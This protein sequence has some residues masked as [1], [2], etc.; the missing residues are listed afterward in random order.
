MNRIAMS[1][2][3][4][5]LLRRLIGRAGVPRDRILLTDVPIGRLAVADL[6]R[7][8]APVRAARSG[9]RL[10]Q[11]VE[12]MCEGLED[13]EFS[14]PGIIVADIGPA[15]APARALDGSTSITIE[16]LT[17]GATSEASGAT[18]QARRTAPATRRRDASRRGGRVPPRDD[19]SIRDLK[20]RRES[21]SAS[22]AVE[23]PHDPRESGPN[24]GEDVVEHQRSDRAIEPVGFGQ[25]SSSRVDALGQDQLVRRRAA[26]SATARRGIGK[27]DSRT[28]EL[29]TRNAGAAPCRAR[30]AARK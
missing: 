4:S 6:H 3:A 10:A 7:R 9:P 23:Q 1:P 17:V 22:P 5:A 14:I 19:W 12:R 26:R 16:A 11:I 18:R 13:A 27:C 8:A 24:C 28:R 25:H 15:D 21:A 30:A 20:L 29:G 2:A